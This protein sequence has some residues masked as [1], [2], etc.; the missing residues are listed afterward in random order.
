MYGEICKS[1][2]MDFEMKKKRFSSFCSLSNSTPDVTSTNSHHQS[3]L[4]MY[5]CTYT[6]V[7]V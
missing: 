3:E 5:K 4:I 6:F 1:L 7:L 2:T